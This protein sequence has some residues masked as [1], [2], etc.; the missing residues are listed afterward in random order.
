VKRNRGILDHK[1]AGN[2]SVEPIELASP[3]GLNEPAPD[4]VLTKLPSALGRHLDA[5]EVAL[6]LSGS[7]SPDGS[8]LVGQ[9]FVPEPLSAP[10]AL[11]PSSLNQSIDDAAHQAVVSSTV[12][13]ARGDA[14]ASSA[15]DA[16]QPEASQVGFQLL[17]DFESNADPTQDPTQ[18]SGFAPGPAA[19]A[20]R[21]DETE[22]YPTADLTTV[23]S[24]VTVTGQGNAGQLAAMIPTLSNYLING[25]MRRSNFWRSPR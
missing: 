8:D 1:L 23:D 22:S 3:A 4:V 9:V 5:A 7:G 15:Q 17:V 12:A 13:L 21:G 20:I 19:T 11:H 25:L 14:R 10:A 24:S 16:S 18:V 2:A 6:D